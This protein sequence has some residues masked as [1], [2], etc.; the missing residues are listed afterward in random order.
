MTELSD[1]MKELYKEYIPDSERDLAGHFR[2]LGFDQGVT[3]CIKVVLKERATGKLTELIAS[4]VH[5]MDISGIEFYELSD[6]SY[7]LENSIGEGT[8][9]SRDLLEEKIEDL[10]Q[11]L[12]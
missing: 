7:W 11:D 4:K 2:A 3:A 1:K 9:V 6:N 12:F 5:L 10:F 8:Q